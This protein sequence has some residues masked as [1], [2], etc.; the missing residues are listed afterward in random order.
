MKSVNQNK[1]EFDPLSLPDGDLSKN[2]RSLK[3]Y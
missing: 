1:F 2:E 3:R